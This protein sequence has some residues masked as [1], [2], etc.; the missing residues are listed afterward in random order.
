MG[1][2]RDGLNVGAL[3]LMVAFFITFVVGYVNRKKD[4]K[5]RLEWAGWTGLAVVFAMIV[6]NVVASVR[7]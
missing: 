3:V 5:N 2:L 4:D 1:S 7:S 6:G